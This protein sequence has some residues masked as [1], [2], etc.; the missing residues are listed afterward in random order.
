MISIDD[1][2]DPRLDDYR[3]LRDKQLADVGRFITEGRRV[4]QRLLESGLEVESVLTDA[5][6]AAEIEPL[7]A[8][9]APLY[10][11]SEQTMS[12]I[13]G[14]KIHT[15]VLAIGLRPPA[16]DLDT[17]MA[18]AAPPHTVLVAPMLKEPANLGA[19]VRTAAA[20]GVTGLL[21]GPLCCDPLLRRCVRVSMGTVFRLPIVR[22][23]DLAGD[24]QRLR[25]RWNVESLATVLDKS[26]EPL[27]ETRRDPHRSGLA[28]LLGH[29]VEGLDAPT[30][31]L[32]DRKI[33]IPMHLGTDSLNISVAAAVFCYHFLAPCRPIRL[34]EA[35]EEL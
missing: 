13:A 30:T 10:V 35:H 25:D 20:F 8:G 19:L 31:A 16:L 23:A 6:R 22:S 5:R 15:G 21:L 9:R 2:E 34:P 7:V 26:A 1:L 17:M 24:L 32:C 18:R 27:H 33:T 14:F 12:R 3:N 28:L 11:V 29:E 4:T